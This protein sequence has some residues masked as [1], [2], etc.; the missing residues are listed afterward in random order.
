MEN[1]KIGLIASAVIVV[2]TMIAMV[3]YEKGGDK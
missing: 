3:F 1:L 2:L